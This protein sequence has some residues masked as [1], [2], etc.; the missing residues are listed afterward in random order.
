MDFSLVGPAYTQPSVDANAQ[1]CINWYPIIDQVTPRTNLFLYPRPGLTVAADLGTNK[2]IQM[3]ATDNTDIYAVSNATLFKLT[4]SGDYTTFSVSTIGSTSLSATETIYYA[5]NS[6]NQLCFA[7]SQYG[8]VYN[9][10]TG[11]LAQL[12]TTLFSGAANMTYMDGYIFYVIPNSNQ[13]ASSPIDNATDFNPLDVTT[14]NAKSDLVLAVYGNRRDLWVVGN[15]S[16][17]IWYNAGNDNFP[18]SRRDSVQVDRGT[19]SGDTVIG[20][21]NTLAWLDSLGQVIII[22]GYSPKV[23]STEPMHAA[24]RKYAS[25]SDAT[26]CSYQENG[27]WFA[28]FTFPSGEATWVYSMQTNLWHKRAYWDSANAQFIRNKLKYTVLINNNV[29]GSGYDNSIVYFVDDENYTD[30]SNPIIRTRTSSHSN[31][32]FTKLRMHSLELKTEGGIGLNTGQG[33]TPQICLQVSKDG[34]HTWGNE[35]WRNLGEMGNFKK[36]VKWNRLG[37][38]RTFT[39][40]LTISDPIKCVLLDASAEVTGVNNTR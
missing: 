5:F 20:I 27:Q 10:S 8:Y 29:F 37:S 14:F 21:D 28:E 9:T 25:I 11:V 12:D 7:D 35:K 31:V 23:I 39:F 38:A 32:Q 15:N 13:V 24:I 3:L 17:E 40:K 1:E 4:P 34:G 22:D 18:F 36:R 16:A 26:A 19:A 33:S 30:N 6:G 2:P